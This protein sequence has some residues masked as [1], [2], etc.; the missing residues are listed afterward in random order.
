MVYKVVNQTGIVDGISIL[1]HQLPPSKIV[2]KEVLHPSPSLCIFV[3]EFVIEDDI[4][5]A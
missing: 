1:D 2:V 5:R 4:V 3:E